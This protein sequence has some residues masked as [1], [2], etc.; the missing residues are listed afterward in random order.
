MTEPDKQ[1]AGFHTTQWTVVMR[2]RGETPEARA[3]LSELCENYWTPVFRFLRREGRNEDESKELAQAFFAR[4]L[5]RNS[6]DRVDPTKGRFRSYLL[7]ALKHFLAEQRRNANRQKRGGDAQQQSIE[8]GGS[9]TS[10]GI[11]IPDPAGTTPDTYFDREWAL[12]VMD[13]SLTKVQLDFEKAGKAQQFEVLKPWLIGD[14]EALS[15][16]EAASALN[17][18]S[19]AMKVAIHRLRNKFGDAIRSE[20]AE[21]VNDPD[22]IREEL[23]YLIEVLS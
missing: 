10:P 14:T 3:A 11:P 23:R 4:L 18:T 6:L 19:G 7:G 17:M 12:A 15:Q 22:E 16:P 9:E 2:A 5:A 21:T 1:P 20:I 13:R 8:A